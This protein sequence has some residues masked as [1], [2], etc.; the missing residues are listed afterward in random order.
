VTLAVPVTELRT[1]ETVTVP[2]LSDFSMPVLLTVATVE[3]ELCHVT[4]FVMV[5]VLLSV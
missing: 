5:C 4:W 3:S 2:A 1:A